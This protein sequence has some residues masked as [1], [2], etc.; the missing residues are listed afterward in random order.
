MNSYQKRKREIDYLEQRISDVLEMSEFFQKAIWEARK[1]TGER[2][3]VEPFDD[4]CG[5]EEGPEITDSEGLLR[6][7]KGLPLMYPGP[8]NGISGDD[9][10]T[11]ENCPEAFW[12]TRL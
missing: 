8:R 12:E 3:G 1:A 9:F 5:N 7:I 10:L 2:L 4:L 6:I 11:P